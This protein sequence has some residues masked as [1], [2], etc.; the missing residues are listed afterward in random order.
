MVWHLNPI[1][2][3]CWSLTFTEDLLVIN[4]KKLSHTSHK[5]RQASGWAFL[6][7]VTCTPSQIVLKIVLWGRLL[8]VHM[9]WRNDLCFLVTKKRK[10]CWENRNLYKIML[11]IMVF[12]C[13]AL[14][15]GWY[16][17]LKRALPYILILQN[18]IPERSAWEQV[19]LKSRIYVSF[20]SGFSCCIYWLASCWSSEM[21]F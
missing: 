1:I 17:T 20:S 6:I 19:D 11:L 13:D 9:Q 2:L 8:K 18:L 4:L 7:N 14:Y 15:R 21:W 3:L 10:I 12:I 16:L 5:L